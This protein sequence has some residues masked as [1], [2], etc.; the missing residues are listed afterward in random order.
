MSQEKKEKQNNIEDFDLKMKLIKAKSK[1]DQEKH[2]FRMRELEE[3]RSLMI[4]R[5][6]KDLERGRIFRAEKRKM[7]LEERSMRGR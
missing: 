1:N 4:L 5:H 7:M 2:N 6:E 3:E